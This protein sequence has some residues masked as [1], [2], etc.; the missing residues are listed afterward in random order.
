MA[1]RLS[2][3]DMQSIASNYG[4][5]CLSGEYINAH[6]PLAW[7][8]SKGHTWDSPY[9]IVKQ[10]AWCNQ[11]AKS[12]LLL[13]GI[14][15]I[16]EDNGGKCLSKNYAN[17]T[18]PLKFKCKNNHHFLI[19][20]QML[21]RGSWC[22]ECKTKEKNEAALIALQLIAEKKGGKCLSSQY[23]GGL[24]KLKWQCENNHIW[25]TTPVLIKEGKW[26][27]RC[28]YDSKKS[29][30][31]EFKQIAQ[32]KGGILLSTKYTNVKTPVKWQCGNGHTW[33]ATP[34]AIKTGYWCAKCHSD[35]LKL[36][37][38]HFQQIAKDHGGILL[39]KNYVDTHTRL[40]W[41]CKEG[42]IWLGFPSNIQK[43][44]WCAKCARLANAEQMRFPIEMLKKHAKKKGGKF[45]SQNYIN[46]NTPVKWQC[47]EG[48]IWMAP[49]FSVLK[50]DSWCGKCYHKGRKD[51]EKGMK[52][53][54]NALKKL[55]AIANK[56]GGKCLSEDYENKHSVLQ[57]KCKAGHTWSMQ[58]TSISK[59]EWCKQCRRDEICSTEL[60][61]LQ[62]LAKTKKGKC[63]S[64]TF[65]RIDVKLKWQC[66]L[67]HMF[68]MT[69][70]AVKQGCWCRKCFNQNRRLSIQDYIA[71]AKKHGGKLLS[72]E[73]IN[74]HTEMHWQCKEGHRW[75]T[76]PYY[77]KQG[78]WCPVCATKIKISALQRAAN[79]VN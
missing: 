19:A 55:N 14:N 46:S 37:I 16:A 77:V 42:H 67:G 52:I 75:K 74:S 29:S 1:T 6:N 26:C 8:C 18:T 20:P 34:S 44:A 79:S 23:K 76:K 3:K 51:S 71:I 54:L 38:E 50:K 60:I 35:A 62:Q 70:K 11:C 58:A 65:S 13:E 25:L 31:E 49:A 4:G 21:K 69:P 73:Y 40:K 12:D 68:L 5:K 28:N 53:R 78:S 48:H 30:I 72:K 33:M 2:I 9:S 57:W 64:P 36:S 56:K 61:K 17:S 66:Q 47:R 22:K 45:L 43:G 59:G 27:R 32:G 15:Q 7:M 39:S 41:Q 24:T 63:L 10:G